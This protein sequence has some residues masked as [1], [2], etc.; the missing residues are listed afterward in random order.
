MYLSMGRE[1]EAH[2]ALMSPFSENEGGPFFLSKCSL[3]TVNKI[4]YS[5]ANSTLTPTLSPSSH[6]HFPPLILVQ[7]PTIIQSPGN[8][9]LLKRNK[10]P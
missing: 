5:L 1:N 6:H 7:I 10:N 9:F 8:I 2:K 3:P 4:P